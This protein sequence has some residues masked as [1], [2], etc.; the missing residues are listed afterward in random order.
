[1]F[2]A[3]QTVAVADLMNQVQAAIEVGELTSQHAPGGHP[4]F[5]AVDD[6]REV[7]AWLNE[8]AG[9]LAS[10]VGP[11][12]QANVERAI[13]A[14][15]D[16]AASVRNDPAAPLP[17]TIWPQVKAL[18]WP[19]LAAGAGGILLVAILFQKRGSGRR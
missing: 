8:N 16:A 2:A 13:S 9:L 18:P 12:V 19:W 6:A 3:L 7:L 14:V 1:M 17:L 11:A 5:A 15:Y 10:G 4:I